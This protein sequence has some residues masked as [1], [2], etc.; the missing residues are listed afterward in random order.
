MLKIK[1]LLKDLI[2]TQKQINKNIEKLN[3]T[4]N[5]ESQKLY[6]TISA[7]DRLDNCITTNIYTKDQTIETINKEY[8]YRKKLEECENNNKDLLEMITKYCKYNDK[9]EI[10]EIFSRIDNEYLVEKIEEE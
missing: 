4:K 2:E 3:E 6:S 9:Y 1:E 7:I 8:D 5:N 10:L